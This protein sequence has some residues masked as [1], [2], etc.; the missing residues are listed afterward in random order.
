MF[1]RLRASI[2]VCRCDPLFAE[3]IFVCLQRRFSTFG[4]L[5]SRLNPQTH[6]QTRRG[7]SS[8]RSIQ[9][10]CTF[11]TTSTSFRR[12]WT[13]RPSKRGSSPTNYH[14]VTDWKRVVK[15]TLLTTVGRRSLGGA[16]TKNPG[17]DPEALHLPNYF[18]I[19]QT[20]MDL[21]TVKAG[22]APYRILVVFLAE[23]KSTVNCALTY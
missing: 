18:D 21:T 19:I 3:E 22:F 23:K 20:P 8:S 6:N 1:V 4:S 13:S 14:R 5:I 9:R 11:Q 12:P 15:P 2:S 7:R 17:L 16:P 10:R